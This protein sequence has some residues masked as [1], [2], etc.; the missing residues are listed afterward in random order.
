M[1]EIVMV[2]AR[3]GHQRV[4]PA[5]IYDLAA[6]TVDDAVREQVVRR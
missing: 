1:P 5:S 3:A 2:M 4:V 6:A